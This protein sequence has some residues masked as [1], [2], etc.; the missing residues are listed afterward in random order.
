LRKT[1]IKDTQK[2]KKKQQAIKRQ[3][4][5][6]NDIDFAR[7]FQLNILKQLR[8]NKQ[9]AKVMENPE[10]KSAFIDVLKAL[11]AKLEDTK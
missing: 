5:F 2:K 8:Q 10:T 6:L 3:S 4:R 1:K 7:D 9:L 11:A